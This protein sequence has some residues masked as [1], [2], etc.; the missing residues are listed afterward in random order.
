MFARRGNSDSKISNHII[1]KELKGKI[2]KFIENKSI[3]KGDSVL[4]FQNLLPDFLLKDLENDDLS[5]SNKGE[6]FRC[7]FLEEN[8]TDDSEKVIEI[9][10]NLQV[11]SY[12]LF[13]FLINRNHKLA[14]QMEVDRVISAILKICL[15]IDK[16]FIQVKT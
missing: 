16:D 15:Q 13:L 9:I 14:K 7:E 2:S 10:S 8:T 11:N 5:I 1:N 3:D 6:N 4:E 12:S